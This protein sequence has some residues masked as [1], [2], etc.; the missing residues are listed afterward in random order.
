MEH[1]EKD[2]EDEIWMKIRLSMGI[3]IWRMTRKKMWMRY[4]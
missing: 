1:D 3:S 4:G 2:D